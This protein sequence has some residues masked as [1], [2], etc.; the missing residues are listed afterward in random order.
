MYIREFKVLNGYIMKQE[1]QVP[2]LAGNVVMPS[3][4]SQKRI[5]LKEPPH[6]EFKWIS[7]NC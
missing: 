3:A 7:T 5:T 6:N 1:N 4:T 2:S